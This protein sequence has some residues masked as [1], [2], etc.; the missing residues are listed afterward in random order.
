M[1]IFGK[2]ALV[3][4]VMSGC[5]F[6][7]VVTLEADHRSDCE[8]RIHK[9]EENLHKEVRKHGEHSRQAAKR[10]HDLDEAREHCRG[11]DRDRD[12]HHRRY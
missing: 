5:L 6:G 1:S 9:A 7:C 11:F 3:S 12:R 4:V 2:T 8:K 10:R